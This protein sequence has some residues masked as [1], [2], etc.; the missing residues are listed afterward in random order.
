MT[1]CIWCGSFQISIDCVERQSEVG[2]RRSLLQG[3][4]LTFRFPVAILDVEAG[5]D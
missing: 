4:G 2:I 5:T 3:T 1:L